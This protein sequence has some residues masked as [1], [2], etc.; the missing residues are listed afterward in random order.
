MARNPLERAP[1]SVQECD[2]VDRFAA[3]R[4]LLARDRLARLG[5]RDSQILD[6]AE[7]LGEFGQPL[8]LAWLGCGGLDLGHRDAQLVGLAGT[9][10]AL[11]DEH[12]EL[13]A[14][15]LPGAVGGAVVGEHG[16]ELGAAEP[17]EGLALRTGR[18]QPHLVGLAVHDNELAAD[19]AQHPDRGGAAA[20]RGA[21][22]ALCGDRAAEDELCAAVTGLVEITAG[23]AHPLGDHACRRHDPVPFDDGLPAAGTNDAAVG[24]LAQQEPEGGD[25]HG[26]AGTG[27]AGE[28]GET[29]PDR[30]PRLADHAEVA[31]EDL[32]DHRG[33]TPTAPSPP[34]RPARASRAP[35][36]RTCA[37][38][39]R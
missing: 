26:L 13:P 2:G 6:V 32:L 38:A 36:G 16:R 12:V 10:I 31:D 30:Q 33:L 4:G 3:R 35:R 11:G 14:M 21:A 8:V 24:S 1:R 18:T 34:R 39:D 37:R 23:V 15:L 25:H 28:H 20:D 22:A 17:V 9:T 5:R 7:A 27:L 29:G 19:L